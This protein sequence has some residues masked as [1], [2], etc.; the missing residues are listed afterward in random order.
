MERVGPTDKV[1]I[2]H[3]SKIEMWAVRYSVYETREYW[4]RKQAVPYN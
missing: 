3:I 4:Q 1:I 2:Y